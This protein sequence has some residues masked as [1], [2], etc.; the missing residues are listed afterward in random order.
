MTEPLDIDKIEEELKQ[1]HW[2]S[3]APL[4]S[5][6]WD[7]I[8]R[9]PERVAALVKTIR[10]L[11]SQIN[12]QNNIIDSAFSKINYYESTVFTE[13]LR[14]HPNIDNALESV[15]VKEPD[16]KKISIILRENEMLKNILKS[17]RGS[18]E[19]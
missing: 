2:V 6:D 19:V 7:F 17:K 9:C 1:I 18:D 5:R 4:N 3:G 12:S 8:A 11:E 16:V 15:E 14:A 10:E 13:G